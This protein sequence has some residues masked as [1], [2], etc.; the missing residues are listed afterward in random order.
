MD[1]INSQRAEADRV[2]IRPK[3]RDLA[4]ILRGEFDFQ[5]ENIF[6]RSID[7]VIKDKAKGGV[8]KYTKDKATDA[9]DYVLN[10]VILY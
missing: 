7:E 4:D 8:I 2:D 5:T 3:T 6:K 10:D 1:K 9:L